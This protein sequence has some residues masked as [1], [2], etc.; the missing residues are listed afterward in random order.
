[1]HKI[2]FILPTLFILALALAMSSCQPAGSG[3]QNTPESALQATLSSD[4]LISPEAAAKPGAAYRFID[5]RSP[6]AF[7]QGHIEGAV[8]IPVQHLLDPENLRQFR[9]K[10]VTFV[11]YGSNQREANGPWMLLNQMGLDNVK[12]LQGGFDYISA[13]TTDSTASY[14]AETPRYNY[15]QVFKEGIVKE[16]LSTTPP[17]PAAPAAKPKVIVPKKKV[18]KEEVEE[19]C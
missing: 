14:L 15:A 8:N 13:A 16:Q 4:N 6:A 10:G 7:E 11:L 18:V 2:N 19:G 17:K 5:L 3:F 1:M 9:E 12:V